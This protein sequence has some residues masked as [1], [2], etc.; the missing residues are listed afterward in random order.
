MFQTAPQPARTSP[1]R[2]LHSLRKADVLTA[3]AALVLLGPEWSLTRHETCDGHLMLL[4][5]T[6]SDEDRVFALDR[7]AAG[8]G[9]MKWQD[10]SHTDLGV[11]DTVCGAMWGAI[12][13]DALC[14]TEAA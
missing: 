7:S 4:L 5:T 10:D 8:I 12:Q 9:L 14:N 3:E 2:A 13:A 6:D 11:F 1:L